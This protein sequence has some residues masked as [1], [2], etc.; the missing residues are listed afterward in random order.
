MG[1]KRKR[2]LLTNE[3][4]GQEGLVPVHIS[5]ISHTSTADL[6][7]TLV[8]ASFVPFTQHGPLHDPHPDPVVDHPLLQEVQTPNV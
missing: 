2:L 8:L 1:K 7:T 6:Q 4:E 5:V 3:L